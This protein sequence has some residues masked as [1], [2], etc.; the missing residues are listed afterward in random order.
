MNKRETAKVQ[1][2]LEIVY[3]N[4]GICDVAISDKRFKIVP[5]SISEVLKSLK[6]LLKEALEEDKP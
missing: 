5:E 1:E 4:L 6:D 3:K 2:A